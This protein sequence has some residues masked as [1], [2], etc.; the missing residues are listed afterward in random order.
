MIFFS[1]I[2][3]FFSGYTIS[4]MIISKRKVTVFFETKLYFFKKNKL[5]FE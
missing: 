4:K 2:K 5:L 3:L 1:M